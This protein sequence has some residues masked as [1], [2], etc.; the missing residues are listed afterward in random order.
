M[1]F[2][3]RLH[4]RCKEVF[5]D[6]ILLKKFIEDV[7]IDFLYCLVANI[8][9]YMLSNEYGIVEYIQTIYCNQSALD[10]L[11]TVCNKDYMHTFFS[12]LEQ[13]FWEE[14]DI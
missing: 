13:I 2:R 4:A 7:S 3:E 5:K 10:N 6:D 12:N 9:S 11:Y 1:K 8:V 14:V